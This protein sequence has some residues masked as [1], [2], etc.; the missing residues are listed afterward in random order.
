[1]IGRYR[2]ILIFL[3]F[4]INYWQKTSFFEVFAG[5]VF[6]ECGGERVLIHRV[7]DYC[8][9]NMNNKCCVGI[10]ACQTENT[11]MCVP[12]CNISV[13]MIMESRSSP[14]ICFN[15]GVYDS[16]SKQCQCRYPYIIGSQCE[17]MDSCMNVDCGINGH[18][19][20]GHCICD[21]M[22]SGDKCQIRQDCKPPNKRWTGTR[23]ICESGYEGEDCDS[24]TKG[25]ICVPSK[26]NA[27]VYSS[28]VTLNEQ[29]RDFLLSSSP[30]DGYIVKPFIPTAK[31]HGCNCDIDTNPLHQSTSLMMLT[32]NFAPLS[33][34][35]N[36]DFHSNSKHGDY[37]HHLYEK[38]Y[39]RQ[40]D[41]EF[42]SFFFFMTVF[43]V[44]II[45]LIL[46]CCIFVMR[47]RSGLRRENTIYTPS[48]PSLVQQQ[49]QQQHSTI[50]YTPSSSPPSPPQ[51]PKTIYKFTM[52]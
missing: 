11:L 27:R 19:S 31:M 25:L 8:T 34:N 10:L 15:G 43:M 37:I 5:N 38:H 21:F 51:T 3:V 39:I 6:N 49:Q 44:V 41:C 20:E 48:M 7:G 35:F 22:F 23:C 52:N 16:S 9:A 24:C 4:Y 18:C 47:N 17:T 50:V 13:E 42:S 14:V 30:P 36:D 29:F 32:E 46:G 26:M 12:H 45:L 1:M 28:L 40:N 33:K 2:F